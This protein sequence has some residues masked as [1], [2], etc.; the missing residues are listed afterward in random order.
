MADCAIISA[1]YLSLELLLHQHINGQV[2]V[3]WHLSLSA[4][5]FYL[6]VLCAV[7]FF[8]V[9]TQRATEH[10]TPLLA[11]IGNCHG[12]KDRNILKHLNS[13]RRIEQRLVWVFYFTELSECCCIG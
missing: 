5:R 11:N 10:Y 6:A 12:N 9:F 3:C 2:F 8:F 1:V 4:G 13:F 7:L